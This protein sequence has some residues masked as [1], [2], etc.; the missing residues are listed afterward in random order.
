[1]VFHRPYRNQHLSTVAADTAEALGKTDF[2]AESA[3]HAEFFYRKLSVLRELRG[4]EG[5]LAVRTQIIK[6]SANIRAIRG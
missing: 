2:T 4:E 3:E 1:M 5:L 6:I